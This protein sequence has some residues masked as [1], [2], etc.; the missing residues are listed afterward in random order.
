M[1]AVVNMPP[2][3]NAD[4]WRL[5]RTDRRSEDLLDRELSQILTIFIGTYG[6]LAAYLDRNPLGRAVNERLGLCAGCD[7]FIFR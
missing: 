7:N 4:D 6:D 2:V 5:L 1:W 3:S